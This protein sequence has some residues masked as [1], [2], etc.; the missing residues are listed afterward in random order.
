MSPMLPITL[1]GVAMAAL[2][3]PAWLWFALALVVVIRALVADMLESSPPSTTR[4]PSKAS[5]A[6]EE[7][8]ATLEGRLGHKAGKSIH[9]A[10]PP[11]SGPHRLEELAKLPRGAPGGRPREI[12]KAY[13]VWRAKFEWRSKLEV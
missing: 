1:A 9:H 10:H 11:A 2:P 8:H 3:A 4:R 5:P 6:F 12:K 7:P 13:R